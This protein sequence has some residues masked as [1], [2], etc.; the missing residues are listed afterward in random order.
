MFRRNENN[1]ANTKEK[2]KPWNTLVLD[3]QPI[4]KIHSDEILGPRYKFRDRWVFLAV[5]N[6]EE[7]LVPWA[8]PVNSNSGDLSSKTPRDLASALDWTLCKEVYRHN[9]PTLEKIRLGLMVVLITILL[10]F[11]YLIY[12]NNTGA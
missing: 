12:A 9:N 10:F 7:A 3:P 1:S 5:R 6:N 2:P 4:R 8:P 11:A